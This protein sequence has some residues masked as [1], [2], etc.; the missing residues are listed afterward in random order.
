MNILELMHSLDEAYHRFGDIKVSI[1]CYSC[2][3]GH[4]SLC[5]KELIIESEEFIIKCE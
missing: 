1:Q 4:I 5:I 2:G 3:Q